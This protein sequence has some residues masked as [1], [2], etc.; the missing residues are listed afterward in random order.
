MIKTKTKVKQ[1]SKRERFLSVAPNRTQKVI[2]AI[3]HLEKCSDDSRY[4][5]KNNEIKQILQAID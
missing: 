5:Y 1:K 4:K 2:K 3:R